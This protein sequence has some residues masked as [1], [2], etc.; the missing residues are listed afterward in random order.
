MAENVNV[1][2]FRKHGYQ[3]FKNVISLEL[4]EGAREFLSTNLSEQ[5]AAAY[6]EAGC[7]NMREFTQYIGELTNKGPTAIDSCT[8]EVRDVISGQFSVESRLSKSLLNI[9]SSQRLK[10]ILRQIL[11]S[12]QT[13]LHM[14]PMAR[15]VLPGNEYSPVPAHQD[16]V[17]N[18]HMSDFITVWIPLVSIDDKCGGV[19]V[20]KDTGSADK[21]IELATEEENF[22]YKGLPV[23]SYESEHC[24]MQ[25]GDIL[26]LNKYVIHASEPNRSDK[27]RYSLDCRLFNEKV[28]SSKHH[29]DLNTM[30]VIA[31]EEIEV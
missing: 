8:K 20:Y 28:T 16:I 7:L 6:K 14:P 3:V 25:E 30:E 22:W 13:F 9:F 15:F 23:D 27:T 10:Q 29:L 12:Q 19:R 5:L 24:E 4:V 1:D 21:K 17:Y 31:P 11:L 26:V 2:F 18:K